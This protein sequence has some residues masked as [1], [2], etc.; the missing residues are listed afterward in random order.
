MSSYFHPP[1]RGQHK[2]SCKAHGS[3]ARINHWK[4]KLPQQCTE[5]IR[6]QAASCEPYAFAASFSLCTYNTNRL[7]NE[8]HRERP[9]A[10]HSHCKVTCLNCKFVISLWNSFTQRVSTSGEASFVLILSPNTFAASSSSL[11]TST[12][13]SSGNDAFSSSPPFPQ[14]SDQNCSPHPFRQDEC[15]MHEALQYCKHSML[16]HWHVA[17]MA[18]GSIGGIYTCLTTR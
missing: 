2:A 1:T 4:I 15:V 3:A 17:A 11:L 12:C 13:T 7:Y 5:L 18:C 14:S 9:L 16:L 6:Q 10:K 8:Y